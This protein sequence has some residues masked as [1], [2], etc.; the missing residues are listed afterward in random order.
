MRLAL[1]VVLVVLV[2]AGWRDA[3]T[4]APSPER[5]AK[6]L[7][8]RLSSQAARHHLGASGASPIVTRHGTSWLAFGTTSSAI[9][10][11]GGGPGNGDVRIY[12]WGG[13]RWVLDG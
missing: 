3:D 13:A 5:A 8:A 11:L 6:L 9:G 12:R 10:Y 7:V 2:S 1:G 4:T